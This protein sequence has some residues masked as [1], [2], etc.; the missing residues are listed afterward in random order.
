MSEAG[1]SPEQST[2]TPPDAEVHQPV[3]ESD[4]KAAPEAPKPEGTTPP[5]GETVKSKFNPDAV[6]SLDDLAN[7]PDADTTSS[8]DAD[9][10][11]GDKAPDTDADADTTTPDATSPDTTPDSD[12]TDTDAEVDT[13][14][15]DEAAAEKLQKQRQKDTNTLASNIL[16]GLSKTSKKK[17]V[18]DTKVLAAGSS[19]RSSEY[20]GNLSEKNFK[21]GSI[22]LPTQPGTDKGEPVK[23]T[24]GGRSG[25]LAEIR[26]LKGENSYTVGVKY[27]DDPDA[28][29]PA[30]LTREEVQQAN[31]IAEKDKILA[32]VD[33]NQKA[34]IEKYLEHIDPSVAEDPVLDEAY[35][36]QLEGAVNERGMICGANIQ[37]AIENHYKDADELPDVAKQFIA[38][39]EGKTIIDKTDMKNAMAVMGVSRF[40]LKQQVKAIEAEYVA[41]G[42]RTDPIAQARRQELDAQFQAFKNADAV[43]AASEKEG[44]TPYDEYLDKLIDGKVEP[45][46]AKAMI[47]AF[48]TGDTEK[49][50]Q[51]LPDLTPEEKKRM[52]KILAGA[53]K[54]GL[55]VLLAAL[56]GAGAGVLWA[57]GTGAGIV[58]QS[59]KAQ[60]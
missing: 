5:D 9:D 18:T 21:D 6:D 29:R 24:I 51:S 49:F 36:K 30:E 17:G 3:P 54:G 23:V 1:S 19:V 38:N 50:I 46:Q 13:T 42:N 40:G 47:Q 25:I 45:D 20:F 44:K 26:G 35:Q 27:D 22:E 39:L 60:H 12:T 52:A 33:G 59:L 56:V 14:A 28:I 8:P 41:L 10:D 58:G 2:P 15:E 34:V 43:W 55:F 16:L 32:A 37:K 4:P 11:S 48:E 53:G 57:A 7:P 31:L